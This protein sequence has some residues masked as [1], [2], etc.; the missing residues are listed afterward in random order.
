MIVVGMISLVIFCIL[1][2]LVCNHLYKKTNHYQNKTW[3]QRRFEN[4]P[5]GIDVAAIGSGPGLY[6]IDLDN[7]FDHGF[8]FCQSPQS[9]EYG[10]KIL[11]RYQDRLN[12]YCIIIIIIICPLNFAKNKKHFNKNYYYPYY[13]LLPKEDIKYYSPLRFI[14]RKFPLLKHPKYLFRIFKDVPLV[15]P[16]NSMI[17]MEGEVYRDLIDELLEG[18][19]QQSGL[20]DLTDKS[21]AINQEEVF[22]E[23]RSWLSKIIALCERRNWKPVFLIP[24]MEEGITELISDEFK[25][26][27]V[28][29]QLRIVNQKGYPVLDYFKDSYFSSARFYQYPAFMNCYGR[30]EF[31]KK[32]KK[33]IIQQIH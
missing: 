26:A 15:D 24:P 14:L 21:Q 20:N 33:D 30:K 22:E 10:Y 4:I 6:D 11:N 7:H 18:W 29:R 8:S 3:Q 13:G 19:L 2:F 25:E 5:Y 12:P 27:F 1:I 31:T 28:D 16:L 9:F 32:I 17:K 23:T